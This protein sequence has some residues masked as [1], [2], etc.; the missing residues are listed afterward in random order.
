MKKLIAL[1]L[2]LVLAL[3]LA[4]CSVLGGLGK[5]KGRSK[6]YQFYQDYF[7]D[8]SY[9][10]ELCD[11]SNNIP[12]TMAVDGNNIYVKT[13]SDGQE[14]IMIQNAEGSYMLMPDSMLYYDLGGQD[15]TSSFPDYSEE[16]PTE[17]IENYMTTGNMDFDGGKYYYE[18]FKSGGDSSIR[19]L[20]DGDKL[21]YTIIYNGEDPETIQEFYTVE[22]DVDPSLFTIPDGYSPLS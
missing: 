16:A 6:T 11:T 1:V 7:V 3:G 8:G 10:M 21:A 12:V 14:I 19:Y 18:A 4:G 15:L 17:E 2:T 13:P 22:S 20:F 5:P 9:Y